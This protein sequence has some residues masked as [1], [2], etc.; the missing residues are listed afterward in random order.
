DAQNQALSANLAA[1]NAVYDFLIDYVAAERAAGEF[2]FNL[3]KEERDAVVE[4]L[5]RFFL[6]RS[7]A[8]GE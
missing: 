4:R 7:H 6:E 1:A 2:G 8:E 5:Q 3:E